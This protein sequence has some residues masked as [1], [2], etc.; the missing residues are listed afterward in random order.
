MKTYNEFK[1]EIFTPNKL[2]DSVIK[3]VYQAYVLG[4]E[5]GKGDCHYQKNKAIEQEY[6][7]DKER[8]RIQSGGAFEC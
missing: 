1:E 8:I 5:E 4:Y 3:T 2:D 7:D 6:E